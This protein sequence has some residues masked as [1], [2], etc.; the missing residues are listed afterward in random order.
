MVNALPSTLS[1][2]EINTLPIWTYDG[3]VR[4]VRYAHELDAALETLEG[5]SLLGFDTEARPSFKRG[6][7]YSTSLIQL[8][9]ARQV[10]LV[11]LKNMPFSPVL[12]AL[13]E[14]ATVTKAGVAIGDDMRGL[15]R[16]HSFVPAGHVDLSHMAKRLGLACFGLR[17]LAAN[18]LRC[19]ISKGSQCSNWENH[20]LTASQI[21]YAA[22][23]AWIGRELYLHLQALKTR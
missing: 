2:E 11:R 4:V 19:R 15:Q 10:V 12:T 5:E 8:A 18:L 20:E 22:T 23:D 6:K 13:L 9:G 16:L 14:N 21:R 3:P 17:S 7:S 1:K